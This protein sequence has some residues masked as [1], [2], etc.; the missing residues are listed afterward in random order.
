MTIKTGKTQNSP[1]VEI[2]CKNLYGNIGSFMV[3]T[4]AE[5]NIITQKKLKSE[6]LIDQTVKYQIFG[7]N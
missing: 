7:I 3:D 6:I 1:L 5:L 2:K 4:G